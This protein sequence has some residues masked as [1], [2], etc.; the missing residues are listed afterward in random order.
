MSVL[1]E[2]PR[3]RTSVERFS[4]LW[5]K[6]V[7]GTSY[8]SMTELEV[9]ALLTKLSY[10]LVGASSGDDAG[11]PH[12][13]RVGE[14][15]V[16]AH[17]TGP[18]T[19]ERAIAF[20]AEELPV[21][22]ETLV[23]ADPTFVLQREP[24]DRVPAVLGAVASGY[25][26]A[27]RDITL[28]EQ[29]QILRA[30]LAARRKAE[31]A[32]R[33]SEA[34]FRAVFEHAAIG[35]GICDAQT[36]RVI[37]ANQTL[38]DMFGYS[39]AEFCEFYAEQFVH[40]DDAH[41]FWPAYHETIRGERDH[42]RMEKQYLRSD[43]N[44]M[45]T[46]V[47]ASLIRD[48]QGNP[49][50][51]VGMLEDVTQQHEFQEVLQ[52]QARYDSLTKLPNR[53]LFFE[54][55]QQTID[56]AGED[57][58]LGLC[59]IDL[60]QFKTTND[61]LGHHMGDRL[62]VAVAQRLEKVVSGEGR[63]LARLSSDEFVVLIDNP[64][65]T[66]EVVSI[67]ESVLRAFED[68]VSID[69]LELRISASI[70]VLER[71][72]AGT[73]AAE[74]MKDADLT[75]LW[76]KSAGKGRWALYDPERNK[77]ELAKYRLSAAIPLALERR[78]FFLEYQPLVSLENGSWYGAEAL[79]RWQHPQ[80]GRLA[81]D[82]FI[83]LAEDTGQIVPLGRWV[84][85]S[86]CKQARQWLEQHG[87]DSPV[88]SVNLAVQQLRAQD[89]HD[90]VRDVMEILERTG[91]PPAKLQLEI[92]ESAVMNPDDDSLGTLH[93]LAERGV[94]IAIDDFGT[95]YSNLAYLRRLPVHGLKL[96]GSFVDGLRSPERPDPVDGRIVA[97]LITLAQTL[98]LAVT[99]EEIETR[100]QAA[101]LRAFGCDIGQG[102]L[103]S[104]PQLPEALSDFASPY[105]M[106]Q[107]V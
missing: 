26:R 7:L 21:L 41:D 66:S 37:T 90:F 9:A 38:A 43:G 97:T 72:L 56:Q 3:F 89:Q 103:F 73:D 4:R 75:L 102:Y 44:S 28:A 70:G 35:I 5:T 11:V 18:D 86:A 20:L 93:E 23:N 19:L 39:V 76:A 15:L 13:R 49:R 54:H 78:E 64:A 58:R 80:Y 100:E 12:A 27:L 50:Y 85:Q 94:R 46:D 88:M 69:A 36:G 24:R 84:L 16:A 25:S 107:Q 6:R 74:L 47:T 53:V 87:D 31:R 83:Q 92:T 60:D 45:W 91:V 96:A 48:E 52:R 30:G 8:V 105:P 1:A 32:L 81:P 17:F 79:V 71:Q 67:A 55:L 29:E 14:A 34:R 42:M 63:L 10:Y 51:L 68:P 62:L 82:K 22:L 57:T 106:P 95:G 77:R 59:Y 40:P 104:R 65:G 33:E 101:R 61:T 2:D 98:G 99:A